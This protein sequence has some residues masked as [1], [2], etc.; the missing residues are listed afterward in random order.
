V[1]RD[2]ESDRVEIDVGKLDK[3]PLAAEVVVTPSA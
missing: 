2:G 3:N 1:T